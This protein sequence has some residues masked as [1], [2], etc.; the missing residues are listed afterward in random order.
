[1]RK[2][3]EV[4]RLHLGHGCSR[5]QISRSV[6]IARS[7]VSEYLYRAEAAGLT[8]PL[9]D[10][11]TDEELGRRLFS[12]AGAPPPGPP[13]PTPD[14]SQVHAE[15]LRRG[16]TLL[17]LWQEYRK[18]HPDGYGYSRF[19]DL[20]NA[21][22]NST[23]LRML[24]HHAPGQKLFLDFAGLTMPVTDAL[25]GEVRPVQV[26][27]SAMGASHRLFARATES[28]CV[29]DWLAV[30]ERAFDFYGALP[31]ILVPDNLKAAVTRADR[32]EPTLNPSFA[33]FARHYDL[34][35]APARP[36]KPRDKAKVENGVLQVERWILAPLRDRTFFS[37]EELNEAIA[38]QLSELDRR[39]M[40]GPG[41]SRYEMFAEVDLPAMRPLPEARYRYAEWKTVKVG[42]DYHVEFEGHRYSVP[43]TL[44]GK[45]V[46]LRI[47]DFS[48]EIFSSGRRIWGH[49]RSYLRRGATTVDEHMPK[50][51]REFAEWTPERITR[52]AS[53]TG[54]NTARLVTE[55]MDARIHPQTA[56]RS[57]LGVIALGDRWGKDR[58]EAA[59]ARAVRFRAFSY[60][61]VKTILEKGLDQQEVPRAEPL[62]P[63]THANLRGADYYAQE[64]SCAN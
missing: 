39:I 60:Q 14:W 46:S 33:D 9:P 42:P 64:S 1:M 57:C 36:R 17:L 45:P 11:L 59:C 63:M 5:K 53:E 20:Y 58:L 34:V 4:L 16:V 22:K 26:F 50:A 27:C 21:W 40:K 52:W 29:P 54:P 49:C 7:T 47:D 23:E 56:F 43:H 48:V 13:R 31:K 37:L 44:R 12:P 35:V 8:W 18:I 15:L 2:I 55:M 10:G 28:Q 30:L 61:A 6:G 3:R 51:H 38:V 62:V 24:Q 41:Q 32:Y 25:T 19:A